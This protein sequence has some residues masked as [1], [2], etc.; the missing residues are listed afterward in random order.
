MEDA[1]PDAPCPAGAPA[2]LATFADLMSLL[3]TFFVLLL[4]FSEMDVLKFKQLAGSM[5]E[6]FGVQ[7]IIKAKEIPKGTSVIT[8][9]FSPGKP[10]PTAIKQIRQ[11][12]TKDMQRHLKVSDSKI[13]DGAST[14]TT[15]KGARAK[16]VKVRV[17][18]APPDTREL[19]KALA[20][21]IENGTLAVAAEGQ[22]IVIRI[23]EKGSFGSGRANLLPAFAPVLT[24]IGRVLKHTPGHIVIAGHTD[25]VP[26]HTQRFRSNWEL[27]AARAA[28][29]VQHLGKVIGIGQQ[30]LLVEGHADT[31]PLV[32]ND[33][34][35]HRARNRR[36][37]IIIIRGQDKEGGQIK[38]SASEDQA[39]RQ[40]GA[41]AAAHPG[42]VDRPTAVPRSAP[43]ALP[44]PA[45][46]AKSIMEP[47]VERSGSPKQ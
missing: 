24:R 4:S 44:P 11:Q 45:H 20:K 37:E 3:M 1:A 32:A 9:E 27:S 19:R 26:I 30:R 29:V 18:P 17:G 10:E 42:Q 25:D 28:S 7:R 13:D 41:L 31:A 8:R 38:L 34:A 16:I 40:Q 22:R 39:T 47:A 23:A 33:S 15:T 6:A 43:G 36:V 5:N 46:R 14:G 35:A 2:W 12:T 21:E